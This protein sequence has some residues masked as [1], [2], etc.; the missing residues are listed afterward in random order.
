MAL[1]HAQAV[2]WSLPKAAILAG[3]VLAAAA[4]H[5]TAT[6]TMTAYDSATRMLTVVSATGP[7]E[8]HVAVDA[9]AWLGNRRLP[10]SQLGAHTGTQVTVAWSEAD[11][12]RTTHTVR[13]TESR[14]ARGQ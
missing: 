1:A 6:G 14:A 10:L 3:V 9:R 13:L 2:L 11:G 4:S 7:T 5:H 8:F 12:L